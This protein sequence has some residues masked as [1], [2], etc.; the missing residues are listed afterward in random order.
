MR[1]ATQFHRSLVSLGLIGVL[2]AL[3]ATQSEAA[4]GAALRA[5]RA[6]VNCPVQGGVDAS[7]AL[8]SSREERSTDAGTPRRIDWRAMLPAVT[9]RSRA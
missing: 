2:A 7:P 5:E 6:I 4:D 3:A 8:A 1:L 9:L